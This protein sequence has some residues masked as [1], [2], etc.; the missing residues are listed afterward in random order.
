MDVSFIISGKYL[1][2]EFLSNKITRLTLQ[3]A[4]LFGGL[5]SKCVCA[6]LLSLW[7]C[8]EL[9]GHKQ[10]R[11]ACLCQGLIVLFSLRKMFW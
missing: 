5:F 9:C 11:P 7:S 4:E 8:C 1:G 3:T 2:V 10:A 6:V